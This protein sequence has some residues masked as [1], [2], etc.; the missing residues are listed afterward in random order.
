LSQPPTTPVAVI[1]GGSSGL[2][3]AICK[4]FLDSGYEV[5]GIGRDSAKFDNSRLKISG[6]SPS[7]SSRKVRFLACDVTDMAAVRDLFAQVESTSGRLD[8]LVN[9]VGLSDRGSIE[10]LSR[11]RLIQLIDANV[12]SALYCSQAALPMLKESLGVVVNIGSLASKVGARYLGAYP[13]AKHALAGLSQQMRLEWK[14]YGVG[15]VLI[16]PGPIQ[17]EDSGTRYIEQV[18][19]TDIPAAAAKP[20]GGTSI[21]GLP[22]MTVAEK[23]LRA[24]QKRT[25]DVMLP[26]YARLLVAAG[27]LFPSLGDWLLLKMTRK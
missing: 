1:V 6:D 11:D 8:V 4:V 27:H 3:I 22:P 16:N 15:V 12:T 17:R 19:S 20:G 10:S 13:A 24:A 5:Y 21:K 2:G 7:E 26:G 25:P 18:S 9:C 23:V 14:A